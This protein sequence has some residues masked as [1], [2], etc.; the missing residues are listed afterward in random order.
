MRWPA[1]FAGDP[2]F[3]RSEPEQHSFNDLIDTADILYGIPDVD[4]AALARTVRTNPRLRWVQVMAAGGGGQV[5]SAAL[6]TEELERVSF[7]TLGWS[8]R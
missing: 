8:A 2:S 3:H 1:D 6:T 7:T 5:K 4:P